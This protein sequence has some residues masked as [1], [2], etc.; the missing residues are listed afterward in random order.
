MPATATT[1][2]DRPRFDV[3]VTTLAF[4][5]E[6]TTC[7]GR[8]YR[9]ARPATPPVVV[10]GPG[11]AAEAAF[12]CERY[13][14]RF[15]RAGYAAFAFDYRGSGRS[16]GTPRGLVD[17]AGQVADWEAAIERVAGLDGV[18]RRV[19][20]WGFDLGGAHALGVAA[21]RRVDAVVAVAPLLDGRALARAHAPGTL[22]RL[23]AAGVGD[24]LRS[25]IGRS[26][27]VPVVGGPGE[28]GALPPE[29][30]GDAYL[31]LVPPGSDWQN[32]TLARG[33]L[34]TIRHRTRSTVDDVACPSLLI[35]ATDD[36]VAP[37]ATVAA[38]ADRIDGATYLRLPVGH[39]DPLGEAFAEASAHQVAF[40]DRAVGRQ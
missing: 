8:L 11:F 22:A 9:P 10:L 3:A 21:S 4:R 31:D 19:V 2:A 12:G 39:V 27:A 17:P 40:L 16:E 24:R 20:L 15:A 25:R 26:K 5:S 29:P 7:R 32:R 33:L 34:S 6:G 23:V 35:A 18:R 30:T 36:D 37:A 1:A 38:A 14:E 28:A 13:A